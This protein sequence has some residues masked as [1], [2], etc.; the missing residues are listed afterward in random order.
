MKLTPVSEVE[1]RLCF[2][3]NDPKISVAEFNLT[4]VSFHVSYLSVVG[5]LYYVLVTV[6]ITLESQPLSDTS[7]VAFL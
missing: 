1:F 3:K 7:L 6:T 4:Q 5:S 2:R